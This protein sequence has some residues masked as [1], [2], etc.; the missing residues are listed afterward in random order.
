MKIDNFL[1]PFAGRPGQSWEQFWEKVLV[2]ADIQA[3]DDEAKMM[4]NFPLLLVDDAFLVYSR[5]S[6]GDRK[7]TK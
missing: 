6:S 7:K 5:M 4:K 1:K 2:L 3:W